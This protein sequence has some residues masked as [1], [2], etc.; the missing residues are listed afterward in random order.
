MESMGICF[1]SNALSVG[2]AFFNWAYGHGIFMFLPA[3]AYMELSYHQLKKYGHTK[4]LDDFIDG[5]GIELVPFD[6]DMARIAA[7]KA[8]SKHDFSANAMDYAI[9]AYA[10][11]HNFPLITYNKKHF[12]WLKEVYTPEE[13]ME[14]LAP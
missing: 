6:P 5:Y 1:D 8:L 2:P 11:A 7:R 4:L 9:G 14:K 12:T 13:L 10:E 3:I